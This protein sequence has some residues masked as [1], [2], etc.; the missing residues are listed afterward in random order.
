MSYKFLEAED[1]NA[2]MS[3]VEALESGAASLDELQLGDYPG[4]SYYRIYENSGNWEHVLDAGDIKLQSTGTGDVTLFEDQADTTLRR[5]E[6]YAGNSA[7]HIY[8][9]HSG[10]HGYLQTTLGSFILRSA[11]GGFSLQGS[12]ITMIPY[13]GDTVGQVFLRPKGSQDQS[14]LYF[15]NAESGADYGWLRYQIDGT[16]ASITAGASGSGTAPTSLSLDVNTILASTRTLGFA[17]G[18]T[19]NEFS[20]D[21]GLAGDSDDAVPTEKAVKAYADAI[22]GVGLSDD[23]PIKGSIT[24]YEGVG[25]EASRDDHV[26]PDIARDPNYESGWTA[27][28][29]GGTVTFTHNL[30][31]ANYLIEIWGRDAG[32]FVSHR[33]YGFRYISPGYSYGAAWQGPLINTLAVR[34]LAA[35]PHWVT[36]KVRLWLLI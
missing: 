20:T 5:L 16:S 34:R 4:G 31:N 28:S 2:L 9:T 18:T 35:D 15:T 10:T 27:L 8:L 1:W 26:H 13:S 36:C 33:N 11:V 29:A 14:N 19:I 17:L 12:A 32:G 22:S 3:R 7:A 21:V 25:A 30:G 23:D 6:I 24:A